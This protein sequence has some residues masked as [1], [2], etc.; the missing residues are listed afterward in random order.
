MFVAAYWQYPQVAYEMPRRLAERGHSVDAIVW[1]PSSND[2]DKQAVSSRFSVYKVPGINLASTIKKAQIYPY[3]LGLSHIIEAL[4]PDIVDSQSHL[5][6]TTA[7]ALRSVRNLG[8]PSIVTVHG[9]MA[10]RDYL[11]NLAQN[12]YLYTIAKRIFNKASAVRCLTRNDAIEIGKYGCPIEKIRII[13]NAV[14]TELFSPNDRMMKEEADSIV[15]AGRFVQEKGL[16]HFVRAASIVVKN[17]GNVK[18]TIIGSGPLERE[19]RSM[20]ERHGL[21]DNIVFTGSATREQVANTFKGAGI[22]ALTSTREGMPLTLLEA[23]AS[24]C[25]TVVTAIPG[26]GDLVKHERNGIVVPTTNP[27]ALAD[28][29]LVLL[30]DRKLRRHLGQ[31]ARRSVVKKYGWELVISKVEQVYNEIVQEV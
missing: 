28:A 31:E 30:D 17:R 13:P 10:K 25:A 22:F 20:V 9:V 23:M 18:F 19:V 7:Q 15:W 21:S 5:F 16:A 11:T 12:I 26:I 4:D 3:L 2:L 8:T 6:L 29:I 24:G 14:D 27:K 1:N